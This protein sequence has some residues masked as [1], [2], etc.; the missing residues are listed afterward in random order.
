MFRSLNRKIKQNAREKVSLRFSLNIAKK[1]SDAGTVY[2][3]DTIDIDGKPEVQFKC[4][5]IM[6]GERGFEPPPPGPE[7][8]S[9]S[10]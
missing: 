1:I 2:K 10:Y 6:V 8:D 5:K 4:L 7:P 3:I 9:S